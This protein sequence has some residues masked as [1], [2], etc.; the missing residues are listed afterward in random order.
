M[1]R[2]TRGFRNWI[3]ELKPFGQGSDR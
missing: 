1:A 3:E 2:R